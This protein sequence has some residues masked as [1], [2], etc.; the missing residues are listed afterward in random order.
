MGGGDLIGQGVGQLLGGETGKAVQATTATATLSD[1]AGNNYKQAHSLSLFGAQLDF[2]ADHALRP[3]DTK[4]VEM[5][6]PPPLDS[7]EYLRLE[8]S[9]GGFG[10]TDPLRFQIPKAMI[11]GM[12]ATAGG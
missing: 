2:G 4:T 1:S 10:G 12:S 6:F 11:G 7:I 8:L 9:P 3:G 5:V